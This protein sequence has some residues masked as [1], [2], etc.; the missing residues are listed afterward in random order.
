MRYRVLIEI[1]WFIH[2]FN[3]VKLKG[4]V[5]LESTHLRLLR[6]I[7]EQFDVVDGLRIK[8][9][10]KTTN[11]DVKAVEY[12]L[13]EK[14]KGG[15]LAKYLEFLHF[16]CTSE[17][18]NNLSYSCMLRDFLDREASPILSGLVQEIYSLALST[19]GVAMLSRTHGQ[20]ATPTTLGKE[21]INFVARLEGEI[22]ILAAMK[23]TGKMNGAVG[24]FNAH[25]VAYPQVDWQEAAKEFVEQLGLEW[26]K[27]TTQIEP[28]DGLARA[29]DSLKRINTIV[30]DFDRDMWAYISL[31]YF[32]QN[33]KKGEVGSST[34]PHKVNPIDFENSEG[35]L[36]IANALF[37][38]LSAK[39]PV[40]RLQRDLSDSTALRN[41]GSACVYAALAWKSTIR[42]L[43]KCSVNRKAIADDLKDRWELLAEPVQVVLRKNGVADAY[44]KLKDLTRGKGEITKAVMHKFIKSL[45][46]SATDKKSLLALTPSNYLGLA[47]K[48][49]EEYE[50]KIV[51]SSGCGPS[52]CGGCKGCD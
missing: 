51:V 52:G 27:Y 45:K 20:T 37:E 12:F 23:L 35:N 24:N 28:H 41:I 9:I 2:L 7:Y 44:E 10:E 11:H 38:H 16:C 1:E 14:L 15:P 34:M 26:N 4:T 17:D 48:L 29:F 39:L 43:A 33:V 18:I 30:L 13:K 50:L 46:I 31:G 22:Q 3:S 32:G 40:S 47:E 42:G 49:V 5:V 36:G 8:E 19:K 25:F 6:S 21:L